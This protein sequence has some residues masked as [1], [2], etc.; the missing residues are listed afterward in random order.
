MKHFN[1][2][3]SLNVLYEKEHYTRHGIHLNTRGKDHSVKSLRYAI[4]DLFQR[5]KVIPIS[6]NWNNTHESLVIKDSDMK[7]KQVK[8]TVNL[9]S[10]LS[11]NVLFI[12]LHKSLH[13]SA[14][15]RAIIR[16]IQY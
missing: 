12:T 10:Q 14:H 3:S 2:V 11:I 16:C 8:G 9:L 1:Y 4:K 6:V 5:R 13:V 15:I 7:N